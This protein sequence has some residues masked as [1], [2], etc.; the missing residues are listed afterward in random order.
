L[1]FAL[2][3]PL[4][5][6]LLE[7]QERIMS[8]KKA[9]LG[10]FLLLSMIAPP[11]FAGVLIVGAVAAVICNLDV[12][13][14]RWGRQLAENQ[15]PRTLKLPCNFVVIGAAMTAVFTVMGLLWGANPEFSVGSLH[16]LATCVTIALHLGAL[17]LFV[18]SMG[19]FVKLVD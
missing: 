7:R 1:S 8:V 3:Q 5:S 17:M 15:Q 10:L 18:C 14:E 2:Q 19:K 6:V 12:A 16:V 9:F 4:F 13:L 11:V